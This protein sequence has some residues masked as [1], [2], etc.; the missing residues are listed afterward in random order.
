MKPKVKYKNKYLPIT[1]YERASNFAST[2]SGTMQVSAQKKEKEIA[3]KYNNG[4]YS[5]YQILDQ[6]EQM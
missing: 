6:L 1:Q 2:Y 3:S 4:A 5:S